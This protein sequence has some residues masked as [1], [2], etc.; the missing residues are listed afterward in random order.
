MYCLSSISNIFR[1]GSLSNNTIIKKKQKLYF[2]FIIICIFFL[3]GCVTKPPEEVKKGLMIYKGSNLAGYDNQQTIVDFDFVPYMDRIN[4]YAKN[5]NVIIYVTSSFRKKKHKLAGIIVPPSKK[6]NH[7][8]GH[9]ID[10]NIFFDN[11]LYESEEIKKS[12]WAKLPVNVKNFLN[13]IQKDRT[14]RWGGD[15]KTEDTVHIDD[16]LLERNPTLWQEL[17]DTYQ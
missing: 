16:K 11:V 12:N 6:S 13:Q 4:S 10:I 15:F 5:S 7:L 14:L 2:S 17:Y 8:V 9:A 1:I 3:S